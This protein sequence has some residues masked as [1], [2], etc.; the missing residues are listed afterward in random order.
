[1]EVL[2]GKSSINC[3]FFPFCHHQGLVP[4]HHRLHRPS[5]HRRAGCRG[6]AISGGDG[7]ATLGQQVGSGFF[8]VS[9][10][11]WWFLSTE[12]CPALFSFNQNGGF[13]DRLVLS[14]WR[15]SN[16]R[17]GFIKKNSTH[18][19][20]DIN[21]Q[22]WGILATNISA[23]S[24]FWFCDPNEDGWCL[25]GMVS[26]KHE[27]A[28]MSKESG[29]PQIASSWINMI[30][31]R[32]SVFGTSYTLQ[33]SN[34]IPDWICDP[35]GCEHPPRW[36]P[37]TFLWSTSCAKA[38]FESNKNQVLRFPKD[39]GKEWFFPLVFGWWYGYILI[40]TDL[41]TWSLRVNA[42]MPMC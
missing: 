27:D 20:G 13:Y 33:T 28:D 6:A 35:A 42:Q 24:A 32:S 21:Q 41:P 16:K 22:M 30:W 36:S 18:N 14:K 3:G 40:K 25:A 23:D 2:V 26:K 1:M 17:I 31:L 4:R 9:N 29:I 12:M 8:W 34:T 5:L 11:F 39:V 7:A 10:G 38:A 37:R 15:A 19:K